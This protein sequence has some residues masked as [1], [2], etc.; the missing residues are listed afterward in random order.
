MFAIARQT[1]RYKTILQ[2]KHNPIL[3]HKSLQLIENR[4]IHIIIYLHW[5][6][7]KVVFIKL[8]EVDGN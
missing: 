3:I 5:Y 2:N 4:Y 7:V 6:E 1:K 8:N